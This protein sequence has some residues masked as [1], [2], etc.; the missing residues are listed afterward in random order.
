MPRIA[1]PV[2]PVVS[3][4]VLSTVQQIITLRDLLLRTK[5]IADEITAG[6]TDKAALESAPD[7]VGAGPTL[8][9]GT[10]ATIY[11]ALS[12]VLAGVNS[13]SVRAVV[14]TFDRG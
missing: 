11:D 13:V 7:V 14:K 9:A 12:T 3:R 2:A 4:N 1:L 6:G 8:P 10:G 5:D